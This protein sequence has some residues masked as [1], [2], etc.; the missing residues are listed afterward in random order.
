MIEIDKIAMPTY[1]IINS[2][3]KLCFKSIM[4][5]RK[6]SFIITI[7]VIE[8]VNTHDYKWRVGYGTKG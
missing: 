2:R 8:Q 3:Y 5:Y 7:N 4:I 6:V 1:L